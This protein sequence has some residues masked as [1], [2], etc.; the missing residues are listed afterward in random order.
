MCRNDSRNRRI[1][2]RASELADLIFR[3][4]RI[5]HEQIYASAKSR[6]PSHPIQLVIRPH[7][8]YFNYD[9]RSGDSTLLKS[10]VIE[11]V[12]A[13]TSSDL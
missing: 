9:L 7:L 11:P 10:I 6:S 3:D 8:L 2:S 5:V 13:Q 12:V 4:R 1:A